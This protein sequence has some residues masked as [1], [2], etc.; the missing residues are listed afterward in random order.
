MR[1]NLASAN[2]TAEI[3]SAVTN[4]QKVYSELSQK[5]LLELRGIVF[6]AERETMDMTTFEAGRPPYSVDRL[7]HYNEF[8]SKY[9]DILDGEYHYNLAQGDIATFKSLSDNALYLLISE[10]GAR[11]RSKID[12]DCGVG[13][14]VGNLIGER[15]IYLTAGNP[16]AKPHP[17]DV[18]KPPFY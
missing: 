9:S 2:T 5:T 15:R 12:I 4:P 6:R 1:A 17:R 11:D 3:S 16:W 14:I 8:L 7:N 10:Y 18:A 13:D